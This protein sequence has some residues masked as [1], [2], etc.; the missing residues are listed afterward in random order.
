M[1]L[2][3]PPDPDARARPIG[4]RRS[5]CCCF[6][7][8]CGI[9]VFCIG[10][11]TAMPRA[12][13]QRVAVAAWRRTTPSA[14]SSR[15]RSGMLIFGPLAD[16]VRRARASLVV[17]GIV[18]VAIAL[19]DPAVAFG[20]QS[21]AGSTAPSS[22]L[23]AAT[24]WKQESTREVGSR[25]D[26]TSRSHPRRPRFAPADKRPIERTITAT[27]F[28]DDYEWL[29]DKD[30]PDTLAYLEAENAYAE[31]QTAHLADAARGDLRRDQAAHPGD[32]P[33]RARAAAA[34]TGTTA[35]PRRVSSTR[36]S[37]ARRRRRRRLDSARRSSRAS[38]SLASRSWSTAT[39]LADGQD[40]FS[41]GAFTVSLDENLLAY[42]T[43]I[44]GDERYTSASRTCAPATCS[45]TR[46]RTPCTASPGPP[47]AATSSTR[48][49][50]TPGAPTRSGGTR[51]AP[52]PADDVLVYHET[53]D[54]LLDVGIGRTTSD[55]FLDPRSSARRSRARCAPRCR[56]PD[57]RVPGRGP[58]RDGVEY[59]VDHAV[60]GGEDRLLVLH[61]RDAVNFTLGHRPDRR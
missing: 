30:S 55:R 44:V 52:T 12:R 6:V 10:W 1:T 60:I 9:E 18:Y 59:H 45:P 27:R 4:T 5:W 29:R 15:S 47:T 46:S 21:A 19:V 8:G 7:A 17:A 36:C 61:N 24:P 58:A 35:A 33:L 50:T 20:P 22:S 3:A 57:R 14:P 51:S 2:L 31:D 32:R 11:L 34:A 28:V 48:R 16:G 53:D 37:A 26:R 23:P 25:R 54:Q 38:T 41:L 13:P 42:S 39:T 49:S 43:D 56:R 40:Y